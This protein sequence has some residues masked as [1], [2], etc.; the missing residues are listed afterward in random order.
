MENTDCE[1][2][3]KCPCFHL[4]MHNQDLSKKK[5]NFNPQIV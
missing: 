3:I 1:G 2:E 5:A 4:S